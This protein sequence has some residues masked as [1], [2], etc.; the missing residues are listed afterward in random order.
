MQVCVTR[1]FSGLFFSSN[2]SYT[3]MYSFILLHLATLL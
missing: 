1:R 2:W 3:F